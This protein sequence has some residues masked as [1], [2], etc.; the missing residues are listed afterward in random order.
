MLLTGMTF[1]A[2]LAAFY[3]LYAWPAARGMFD[4]NLRAN[5]LVSGAVLQ[6]MGY[7]TAVSGASIQSDRF[8]VQVKEGCDAAE[9]MAIFLA[10]VL[11]FPAGWRERA[12]GA[13]LGIVAL[14][15]LNV[16][17]VVSL[18]ITGVHFPD[19]FETMHLQVWQGV[20][21]VASIVAGL[22][23]F[24]WVQGRESARAAAVA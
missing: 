16:A 24:R 10:A 17:R 6:V 18:F 20:F 21:I 5:A 7:D 1:A 15:T 2:A 3:A 14:F 8:A 9:P 12:I 13:L 23:W 19:A 4:A 22:L 11:A